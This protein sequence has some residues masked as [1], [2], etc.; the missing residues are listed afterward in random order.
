MASIDSN[1]VLWMSSTI[2]NQWQTQ[3]V[4]SIFDEPNLMIT[5]TADNLPWLGFGGCF[6]ELG[7]IA[8]SKLSAA[9]RKGVLDNLFDSKMGCKFNFCRLPVGANDYSAIWYSLDETPDD[10]DLKYFTIERDKQILIPYIKE[11]LQR[12]PDLKLF[13]SPW[14]PPT[15][16]KSPAVYNFGTLI[17]TPK[18]LTT[19]ANYFVKFIQSYKEQNINI[20][21][22]HP[23]NE[24]VSDQKFP[25]CVTPPDVM[26]DFIKSYL[27]PAFKK[28]N[29]TS[30]IWLGTINDGDYDSWAN[31]IFRDKGAKSYIKGIALQWGGKDALQRVHMSW[32][33]VPIIQSENECNDGTNTWGQ[34]IYIAH[35]MHHYILNGVS[36]YIYWNMILEPE[37]KSSWGWNQ[38]SLIT[39]RD[40][41]VTYN[42]EYYVMKHYSYFVLPGALR[43]NLKGNW[44][45][46]AVAFK[47]LDNSIIIVIFN[48][49]RS[50]QYLHF[51]DLKAN[52][53]A[54]LEPASFNTFVIT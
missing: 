13:A 30:E 31:T 9:A 49:L 53:S 35:L 10:F 43:L 20:H 5:G 54:P 44:V 27:G 18:V 47:N 7:W 22:L 41:N 8:L 36:G 25:S 29:I 51:S 48:P 39:I 19:Y 34:G 28:N 32:P 24:P 40:S 6:N 37:G 23:Q 12:R 45:G 11:A 52:F 15:W 14:S 33:E 3:S 26:Q 46:N 50:K 42:P 16:L 2:S 17:Q 38:N 21:Q 4:V 1:G